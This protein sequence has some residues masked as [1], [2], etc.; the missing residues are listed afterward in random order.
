MSLLEVRHIT[1]QFGGLTALNDV[2]F[3]VREGEILGIIGP[4][5]AGKTTMFNVINGFLRR[6]IGEILFKGQ[7][8]CSLKPYEI[9]QLRI[10]RTFQATTLF[11]KSTVLENVL[12]GYHMNY[13]VSNWKAFFH[14]PSA[15][16]EDRVARQ[17]AVEILEF[18]GIGHLKDESAENLPHG[19]QRTLGICVALACEPELLMLDEPATGM[20]PEETKR[21]V[22]L[23]KKIRDNGIT[24]IVI[25]HDMAA[26]TNLCDRI[27]ALVYGVKIAEGPVKEVLEMEE[28]IEAYL[29]KEED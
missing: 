13:Q 29:G 24:V 23:T 20:N 10:G 3:D 8:L 16:E 25:E 27:A 15:R 14:A 1:K 6:T 11:M 28:L 7:D 19:H 5:G 17:R 2:S 12:F 22:S 18:M 26:V 9:G 21:L 4:N